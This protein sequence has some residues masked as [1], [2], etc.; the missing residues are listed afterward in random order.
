MICIVII[1]TTTIVVVVILPRS[2]LPSAG[3]LIVLRCPERPVA[4]DFGH[5]LGG[6]RIGVAPRRLAQPQLVQVPFLE[7]LLFPIQLF[8]LLSRRRRISVGAVLR[9]A[10]LQLVEKVLGLW[11]RLIRRRIDVVHVQLLDLLLTRCF[12][13]RRLL[14]V[15]FQSCEIIVKLALAFQ[16]GCAFCF[17]LSL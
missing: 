16:G 7:L 2:L 6:L 4:L 14:C 13:E 10:L 11:A 8:V 15:V 9:T 1:I 17:S 12:A 3:L 5:I